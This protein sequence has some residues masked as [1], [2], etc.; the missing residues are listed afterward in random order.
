MLCQRCQKNEANT[1][2][3][4]IINGKKQE[5]H[6]CSEC[7]AKAPEFQSIKDGMEYEIGGFLGGIFGNKM[8]TIGN[9]EAQ[10]DVCPDCKMH[11]EEFLNTGRLGCGTCYQVFRDRLARPLR[12]IHGTGEHIGKVPSRVGGELK[13]S[14]MISKLEAELNAMV[15]KQEFEK[16][17]ELRD[18][19]RE[20]KSETQDEKEA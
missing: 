16:A 17:A 19:I 3:T 8:K 20:L 6:L 9:E 7:A 4:R 1:H 18:K 11:F 2:L 13:R 14:R 10:G 5:L 15:L 12:Q